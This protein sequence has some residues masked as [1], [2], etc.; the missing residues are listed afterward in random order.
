VEVAIGRVRAALG[1]PGVV[2]TVVKRGY[3]LSLAAL[4]E[5]SGRPSGEGDEADRP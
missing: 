3:R 4:G 2:Q 5:V 1:T